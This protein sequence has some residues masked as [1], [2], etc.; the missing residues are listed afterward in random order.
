MEIRDGIMDERQSVV[1]FAWLALASFD[2][3]VGDFVCR[4]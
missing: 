3:G 2:I 1:R 4:E